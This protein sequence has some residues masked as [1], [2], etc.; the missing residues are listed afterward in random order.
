MSNLLFRQRLWRAVSKGDWKYLSRTED[1]GIV[2]TAIAGIGVTTAFVSTVAT[3]YHLNE[4]KS[5][6]EEWYV[7]S[8]VGLAAGFLNAT[9]LYSPWITMLIYGTAVPVWA[10]RKYKE[11]K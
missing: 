4:P 2:H 5:F 1:E 6:V 7:S 3:A 11:S 10:V 8:C 9:A